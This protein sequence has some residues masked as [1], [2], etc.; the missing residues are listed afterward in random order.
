MINNPAIMI[1][2]AVNRRSPVFDGPEKKF[3]N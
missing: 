2:I 1:T 3:A